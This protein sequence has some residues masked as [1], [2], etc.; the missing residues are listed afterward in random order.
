MLSGINQEIFLRHWGKPEFNINTEN[1]REFLKFDFLPLDN[2]TLGNETFTAWI[3]EKLDI[4]V[5]FRKGMLIAH[6]KW[7]D[8]RGNCKRSKPVVHLQ[9][10]K[11]H[12][13]LTRTSLFTPLRPVSSGFQT[14]G[15]GG[16]K[17][18][19]KEKFPPSRREYG[20]VT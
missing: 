13:D 14:E 17:F 11:R 3:Y 1:L 7:S 15:E 6:F 20:G 2:D 4:F 10:D 8:L 5:L 19:N 16:F 12:P 18:K 9:N